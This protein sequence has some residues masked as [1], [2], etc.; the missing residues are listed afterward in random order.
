MSESR[1]AWRTICSTVRVCAERPTRMSFTALAFC[2]TTV[3]MRSTSPTMRSDSIACPLAWDITNGNGTIVAIVDTGIDYRHPDITNN[4][5]RN[6]R[7][8]P[9]NGRDDD[10]NGFIDDVRGWDFVGHDRFAPVQSNDPIDRARGHGT[11]VA[12]IVAAMGNNAEGVIGVAWG[13][14]VMAVSNPG[15]TLRHTRMC[16]ST[17][18][19]SISCARKVFPLNSNA[20]RTDMQAI[21]STALKLR[22]KSSVV[23]NALQ[24]NFSPANMMIDFLISS[25]PSMNRAANL[26]TARQWCPSND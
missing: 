13:A 12:G 3:E 1:A 19:L 6:S 14:T 21:F 2:P 16:F 7:E 17:S 22:T 25:S 15:S 8:I 11:H 20:R 10:G 9:G 26:T 4:I 18:F 23:E 5:W 24:S